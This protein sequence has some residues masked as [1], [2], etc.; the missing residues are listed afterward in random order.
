MGLLVIGW[1]LN[2]PTGL[3]GKAD[4]IGYAVCHRIDLRSFHIGDRQLSLCARC[5]GQYLGAMLGIV[6]QLIRGRRRAG[7]PP[8]AVIA[9]FILFGIL[10]AM[11][12]INSYIH[13]IPNLSHFYIY[14]PNNT[15]R[16]VTGMG[17][18]LSI[19]AVLIPIFHQTV[20]SSWDGRSAFEGLRTM[21]WLLVAAA[22]LVLMILLEHPV[23]LYP[24]TIMSAS[25][26]LI[27]LT[28]IYTVVLFIIIGWENRIQSVRQL[29][30]PLMIGFTLA[31][32][33]IA[34]FDFL[35]YLITGTWDGFHIG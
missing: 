30:L 4:A 11:D 25:G 31:M 32:S 26:V 7:K 29:I 13:L 22:G 5:T 24:L 21:V 34:L 28:M 2:T 18:G 27:L 15:L 10:Y 16:L 14:D 35:R 3:L 20:W 1:L 33:Q 12:G 19:S 8:W 9:L 6:F 17:M 23:I